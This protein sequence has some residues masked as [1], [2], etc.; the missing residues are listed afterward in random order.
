MLINSTHGH[1]MI[2]AKTVQIDAAARGILKVSAHANALQSGVPTQFRPASMFPH[3]R[4]FRREKACAS[5]RSLYDH[6]KEMRTHG[7]QLYDCARKEP[8]QRNMCRCEEDTRT[9][10]PMQAPGVQ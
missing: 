4:A 6:G 9:Y 7:L 10:L 3:N 1:T 2:M 5:K 8:L